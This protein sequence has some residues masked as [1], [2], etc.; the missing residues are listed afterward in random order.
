M[1]LVKK[2]VRLLCSAT[3]QE[4]SDALDDTGRRIWLRDGGVCT[5][6]VVPLLVRGKHLEA[7]RQGGFS[8]NVREYLNSY[9]I[10]E[11]D[12]GEML[13][14]EA[15][16]LGDSVFDADCEV[17]DGKMTEFHV[18]KDD[19]SRG[20]GLR[21]VTI[22]IEDR[23]SLPMLVSSGQLSYVNKDEFRE[24]MFE[25]FRRFGKFD[26]GV[27]GFSLSIHHIPVPVFKAAY[28]K[29]QDGRLELVMEF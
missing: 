26:G 12:A 15:Y 16:R 13:G 27:R 3:K 5:H 18:V 24:Q 14:L 6:N 28:S 9:G 4:C 29:R 8:G 17:T 21:V 1:Y 23:E 19:V 2:E 20:Y 10:I 11:M 22:R 25:Y 7:L